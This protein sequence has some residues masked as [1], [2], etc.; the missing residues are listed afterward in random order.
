MHRPYPAPNRGR[1]CDLLAAF[2][3][4]LL[5]CRSCQCTFSMVVVS[6]GQGYGTIISCRFTENGIRRAILGQRRA[7]QQQPSQS[8]GNTFYFRLLAEHSGW[9]SA[10]LSVSWLGKHDAVEQS[11]HAINGSSCFSAAPA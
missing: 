6:T 3:L 1:G 8:P 10:G 11:D 4:C 9:V 2:Y 5:E 7:C